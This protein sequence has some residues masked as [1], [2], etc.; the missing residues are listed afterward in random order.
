MQYSSQFLQIFPTA[1]NVSLLLSCNTTQL[2]NLKWQRNRIKMRRGHCNSQ[3][4]IL[5][6]P[7]CEKYIA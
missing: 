4:R 5:S 6:S 2:H 3:G 1:S 7:D